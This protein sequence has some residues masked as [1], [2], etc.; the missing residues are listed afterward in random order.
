MRNITFARTK[1]ARDKKKRKVKNPNAIIG[2]TYAGLGATNLG[3]A[4]YFANEERKVQKAYENYLKQPHDVD[5]KRTYTTLKDQFFNPEKEVS[6]K[7]AYFDNVLPDLRKSKNVSLIGGLTGVVISSPFLAQAYKNKIKRDNFKMFTG[8]IEF[9][10]KEEKRTGLSKVKDLGLGYTGLDMSQK[11][12]RRGLPMMAGVRLESHS[13]SHKNAREILRGGGILDPNRMGEKTSQLMGGSGADNIYKGKKYSFITGGLDGPPVDRLTS[14]ML[15]KTYRIQ[16]AMKPEDI[17]VLQ[18]KNIFDNLETFRAQIANPEMREARRKQL[19]KLYGL[20]LEDFNDID[21]PE[22]RLKIK[23]Q[24]LDESPIYNRVLK[25]SQLRSL[26]SGLSGRSLYV[27]GSDAFYK[28]N[29]T[30]D[31]DMP[32]MAMKTDKPLKVYGNR[33]SATIGAIQR[34][35]LGNLMK[36]NKGRVAGGVAL[37]GAGLAAGK[38]GADALG[39]VFIKPHKREDGTKVK[40]FWRKVD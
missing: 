30:P 28:A 34:E 8:L 40:R 21:L 12:I 15:R 38:I 2:G 13:T 37:T 35:G 32:F 7:L 17:A 3:L 16:A 5:S 6:R 14:G 23:K 26:A 33:A 24:I 25:E 36:A 20:D 9:A 4:G 18:R 11:M 19:N 27:G 22:N 39:R 31:E 10:K 1:G 29:F